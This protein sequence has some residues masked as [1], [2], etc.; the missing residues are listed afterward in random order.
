M[1]L[2]LLLIGRITDIKNA[3]QATNG[4]LI[5]SLKDSDS[6]WKRLYP[7]EESIKEQLI[8]VDNLIPEN[9][10]NKF[11]FD[12]WINDLNNIDKK[13]KAGTLSWQDYSNRL[14]DNEKWI[15]KWGRETE[16]QIRTQSDLVKAN[17]Q[18][19]ASALAHN[20]AIKAQTFS[21]KAGKVALQAL[22]TAGN[23]LAM[24]VISKG[25]ELTVKGIDYLASASKHAAESAQALASEM[26]AS[27]SSM[28]S[29]AATLSDLNDDYKTLSKGVNKIGENISLSTED[30]SRY[31][32]II[33]QVSTIMPG[34]TTYFNAQG[35]KIV[36]ATGKL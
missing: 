7:S 2:E 19:R 27:I 11:D 8:D 17:Q 5:G 31:K 20:E 12:G 32:D 26:N 25:I 4:D 14:D 3:F 23:M 15:A 1:I 18:A 16:G 13:V 29:N 35:E 6:I 30:Y 34:L 21:A 24:W 9:D 10:K 36:F 22:A 28:S 33:N